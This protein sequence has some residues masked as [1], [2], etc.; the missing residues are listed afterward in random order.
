MAG[1]ESKGGGGSTYLD[2]VVVRVLVVLHP[3][4]VVELL[5]H[6][7]RKH[8]ARSVTL[9]ITSINSRHV[10]VRQESARLPSVEAEAQPARKQFG[11]SD[12][13]LISVSKVPLI[14]LTPYCRPSE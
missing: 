5:M 11:R 7:K 1:F 4:L 3:H 9:H 13:R 8:S 10:V 14:A 6:N 2:R 12:A